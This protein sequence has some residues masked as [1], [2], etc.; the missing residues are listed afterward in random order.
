MNTNEVSKLLITRMEQ[1]P[2]L[3][4]NLR[5]IMSLCLFLGTFM[6]ATGMFVG[7]FLGLCVPGFL[8]LLVY[9]IFSELDVS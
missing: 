4:K 3:R 1:S 9:V 7:W 8:L 5:H 6:V 2:G